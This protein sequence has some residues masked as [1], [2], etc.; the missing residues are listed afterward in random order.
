MICC[1]TQTLGIIAAYVYS[2]ADEAEAEVNRLEGGGKERERP[3]RLSLA[4]LV[5]AKKVRVCERGQV[6]EHEKRT[7]VFSCLLF[8]IV[9]SNEGYLRRRAP[10]SQ[11]AIFPRPTC[12][13]S[14]HG[15][16]DRNMLDV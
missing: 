11:R 14:Q 9:V 13:S 5:D 15:P 1:S 6:Y 10:L 2:S 16:G 12:N 4:K 8:W 7:T 3:G